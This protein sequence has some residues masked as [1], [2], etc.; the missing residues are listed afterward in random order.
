MTLHK[1]PTLKEEEATKK[2]QIF[3]FGDLTTSGFEDE[4]RHL[5]HLKH[6]PSLRSFFDQIGFVLRHEV[7]RLP[8]YQQDLFPRFTQLLDLVSGPG[9]SQPSPVLRFCLLTVCQIAQI[10]K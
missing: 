8:S 2:Y 7:G 6:V 10:L 4:L 9:E 1:D 5:A 3:L